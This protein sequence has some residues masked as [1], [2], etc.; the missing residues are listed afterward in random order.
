MVSQNILKELNKT[1]VRY[2]AGLIDLQ[3]CRQ[4]LSLLIAMLKAYED[5]V[6]EEQMSRIQ[7]VLEERR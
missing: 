4:E 3:R 7:A 6:M 5:T 2:R 1:L